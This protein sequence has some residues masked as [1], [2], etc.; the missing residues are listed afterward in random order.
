MDAL[1]KLP[2]DDQLTEAALAR[3]SELPKINFY[4]MA[5]R[6][7]AALIPLTDLIRA[8]VCD[9]EIED[10]VR[11]IITLRYAHVSHCA[12]MW[13]VHALMARNNGVTEKEIEAITADPT[14]TGLD[15]EGNLI[16][17]AV[18]DLYTHRNIQEET[19]QK[20]QARYSDQV[21]ADLVMIVGLYALISI[22][23]DGMGVPIEE[24]DPLAS[25]SKPV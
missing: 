9:L 7:D 13:H 17:Q 6:V 2:A 20:L 16:C 24:D 3:I 22:V 4:R 8:I 5:A 12:Y 15:N 23:I 18:D 19:R 14:V 25:A 10:R 21:L 11:E 1:L